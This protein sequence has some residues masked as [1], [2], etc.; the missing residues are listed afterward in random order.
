M[1]DQIALRQL[2]YLEKFERDDT[3]G[4]RDRNKYFRDNF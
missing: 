1:T 3:A 4:Q 2:L